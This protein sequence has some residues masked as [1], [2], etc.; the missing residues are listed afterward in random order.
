VHGAQIDG[1]VDPDV[2]F[3]V[4]FAVAVARLEEKGMGQRTK[5]KWAHRNEP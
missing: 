2:C 5:N 1:E 3:V 4:A